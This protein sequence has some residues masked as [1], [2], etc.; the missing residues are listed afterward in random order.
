PR[1]G[2]G[3]GRQPWAGDGVG[4]PARLDRFGSINAESAEPR[5]R[6]VRAWATEPPPGGSP[7]ASRRTPSPRRKAAGHL[8]RIAGPADAGPRAG[9]ARAGPGGR[10]AGPAARRGRSAARRARPV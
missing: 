1:A 6:P 7:N 3:V 8:A 5:C 4:P 9:L 10:A 2:D